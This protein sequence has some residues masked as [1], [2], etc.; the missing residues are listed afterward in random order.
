MGIHDSPERTTGYAFILVFALMSLGIVATGYSYHRDFSRKF[1]ANVEVQLSSI[2]EAKIGELALWRA[3]RLGDGAVLFRNEA[4]YSLV[5]RYLNNPEDS[6]A[7]Q[8]LTQWLGKYPTAYHYARA[9]LYDASGNLIMATPPSDETADIFIATNT[10][11]IFNAG[12]VT[13]HDFHRNRPDGLIHLAILVPIYDTANN[14]L[15]LGIIAL[16][17]N[18]DTYLYPFISSWPTPSQTAE[19]LLLRSEGEEVVYLNNLKF[20]ADTALKLKVPMTKTESLAVQAVMGKRGILEGVGYRGRV[21]I[22]AMGPVPGSPWFLEARIDREEVYAPLK[23]RLW[24]MEAIISLLIICAGAILSLIW[25]WRSGK[26]YQERYWAAQAL[27]ESEKRYREVVETTS[28]FVTRVD[29]Q[30]RFLYVNHMSERILGMPP[31]ECVGLSAFDFIHPDDRQRDRRIFASWLESKARTANHENRWISKAGQVHYLLWTVAMDYDMEGN[32]TVI[33][34]IATDITARKAA[35]EALLRSETLFRNY[36]EL[37]QVGMAITSLDQKWLR[38]NERLCAMLGYTLEELTRMTWTELT[39][40]DDLEP[41]LLLFRKVISGEISHY[42]LDKRFFHKNGSV[43]YTRL[44]LS[45]QRKPD[46][47]IEHFIA[48][49][50]D[51]TEL[52]NLEREVINQLERLS[53]AQK[54]AKVGDWT[55]DVATGQITW[56]DEIYRLFGVDKTFAPSME[57]YASLIHPDDLHLLNSEAYIEQINKSSHEIEYR[58]V[59]RDTGETKYVLNRGNTTFGPDGTPK[60]IK[61]TLQDITERKLAEM[62]LAEAKERAEAATKLKDKFVSLVA[63]DLRSPFS[64]MM[65]LMKAF[66]E[67]KVFS[68]GDQDK[69]IVDTL[70][71]SGERMICMIDQLLKISRLQTGDITPN[72]RFFNARAA[73]T[74]AI[75]AMSHTAAQK[76]IEIINQVPQDIRLYADPTL[77]GEALMNIFSNAIKFC[78]RGDTITFFAP[79]DFN[80]AIAIRDTGR[81]IDPSMLGDIFKHEIKTTTLGTA[82]EMGTGLGL[83]YSHDIIKAHGGRLTV[84]SS[85]GQG[86]L[87]CVE[88]PQVKPLA[89]VVDDDQNYRALVKTYLERLDLDF[90][91]AANGYQALQMVEE[92]PPHIIITDLMMTEMDGYELLDR[93]KETGGL[94]NIPVIVM[95]A[96]D[97]D[98]RQRAFSHGADDFVKKPLEP[99]DFIPRVRRFIG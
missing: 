73:V 46:G 59:T 99:D 95:T 41:D 16:D 42:E 75:G 20:L 97:R 55:W 11:A 38:V 32:V 35:E 94:N 51:I 48:S 92:K 30:G 25:R 39:Y 82:G 83:P 78:S 86:A 85:P 62:Q 5:H 64:S 15:P 6:K 1:R 23:E 61:G 8:E 40:P 17:I 74:S 72:P 33:N 66:F 27:A 18:P 68:S 84:E 69:K 24:M 53:D 89:L 63:H 87:F 9:Y 12:Q 31:S 44:A 13:F 14:D 93:L 7:H 91:E 56:S 28:D 70:I 60:L 76:G 65:G 67:R 90:M 80:C 22:A 77:F 21:S 96:A 19:T 88:L 10:K 57:A 37:G 52:K 79:G 34:S 29:S 45:C 98:A 58:I 43:V 3:E 26:F 36:F 50:V 49:L 54:I 71:Q 4:L 47:S 2:A 81:G